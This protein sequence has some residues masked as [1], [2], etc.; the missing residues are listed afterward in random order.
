MK[1]KTSQQGH[2][3]V[4]SVGS[5]AAAQTPLYHR[6]PLK[7][8]TLGLSRWPPRASLCGVGLAGVSAPSTHLRVDMGQGLLAPFCPT[9]PTSSKES[10]GAELISLS[11]KPEALGAMASPQGGG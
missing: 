9:R 7:F 8:K 11:D 1:V 4:T 10:T 5:Q 3:T 6:A 2:H